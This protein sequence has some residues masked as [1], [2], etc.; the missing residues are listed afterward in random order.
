MDEEKQNL[1]QRQSPRRTVADSG[2]RCELK[3]GS[4]VVP[5]ELL[6][7]SAGGFSVLINHLSSAAAKQKA[8]LHRN[9][10]WFN[11]RIIHVR[12]VQPRKVADAADTEEGPWFRLGLRRLGE[13]AVPGQP[14]VSLLAGKLGFRLKQ[15]CPSGGMLMVIGVFLAVVALA[16]AVGFV[17]D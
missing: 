16:V 17:A 12:E 11:V 15:C 14:K 10:I 13:V 3:I 8:Q 7:Q 1:D 4:C 2:Q 9:G 5:A 6:D